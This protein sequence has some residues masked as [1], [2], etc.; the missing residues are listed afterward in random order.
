MRIV[1]GVRIMATI[2]ITISTEKAVS[3]D[4]KETKDNQNDVVDKISGL[5]NIGGSK[6]GNERCSTQNC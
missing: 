1:S 6:S 5:L 3:T 4:I 2:K